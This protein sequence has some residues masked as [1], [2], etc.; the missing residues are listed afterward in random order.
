MN[1]ID[2]YNFSRIT[3]PPIT[4]ALFLVGWILQFT[5][6]FSAGLPD[7]AY[8]TPKSNRLRGVMKAWTV[9]YMPTQYL[10]LRYE[11]IFRING[12]IFHLTFILLAFTP[13]HLTFIMML[14]NAPQN[15]SFVTY[16]F[17]RPLISTVFVVSGSLI[18]IRWI[19][20]YSNKES[21]ARSIGETGDFIGISLLI[22]I[23]ITG[24][25]A[26]YGLADYLLI[27]TIH[28][29]S[30]QIFVMYLPFSKAVHILAGIII[31]TY[32]GVRRAT[33]RV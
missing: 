20:Q 27:V 2:L 22:L 14:F 30:I 21:F 24:I 16:G 6:W 8:L 17:V 31:R 4:I 12:F 9:D 19:I 23:A 18:L 5:K 10:P 1:L 28:F 25:F 29:I 11:P 26:A 32:Y 15:P 3:L 33:V 7:K 13:V